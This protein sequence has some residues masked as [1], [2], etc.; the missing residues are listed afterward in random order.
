MKNVF[1]PLGIV[2]AVAAV[3]AGYSGVTNAQE[4]SIGNTGD[5]AIIP[6]YT[7]QDDWVTG[8]HIT[9][10]SNF[11][12]VVKLRLRRGSDSADAM[13]FNLVRDWLPG[14]PVMLAKIVCD[15]ANRI[16]RVVP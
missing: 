1:K 16:G 2:A 3:T 9:N 15:T 5:L 12:R 13:D 8:V 10:T 6:Y 14:F 7:V 4:R 11:T